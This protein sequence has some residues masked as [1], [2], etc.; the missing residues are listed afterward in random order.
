MGIVAGVAATMVMDIL[1]SV[2]RRIGLTAGASGKWVGRWYLGMA[3][4][5]FWHTDISIVPEQPQETQAAM[6]G[7]YLIGIVLAIAYFVS[8]E[9]LGIDQD[10]FLTAVGFGIA[11]VIFPL[12]LV[13]PALGFG[14]MGLRC[15]LAMKPVIT[16]FANHLFYGL[17]LWLSAV[18]IEWLK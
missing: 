13:Y 5:Q 16:S 2:S 10:N 8:V 4:G 7:H 1:G 15:P 9:L 3:H 14:I 11:T 18:V 6:T 12:F 17:G